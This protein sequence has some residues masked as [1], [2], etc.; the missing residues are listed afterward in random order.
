MVDAASDEP[1][2]FG[3]VKTDPARIAA[4]AQG[5]RRDVTVNLETTRRNLDSLRAYLAG[6]SKDDWRRVGSPL[7]ARRRWTW[8][9]SSR[10]STSATPSSTSTSSTDWPRPRAARRDDRAAP[11]QRPR[12]RLVGAGAGGERLPDPEPPLR[13]LPAERAPRPGGTRRCGHRRARARPRRPR[14]RRPAAV[15]RPRGDVRGVVVEP[16]LRPRPAGLVGDAQRRQPGAAPGQLAGGLVDPGPPPPGRGGAAAAVRRWPTTSTSTPR[17]TTPRTWGACSAPT[18]NRCCPTGSTC[19]SATTAGPARWW[20]AAPTCRDRAGSGWSRARR[21][22]GPSL[23]LDIELEV[24]TVVGTGTADGSAI[25]PDAAAEHVFGFVLLNDW[26]ARD[27]QAFEYQPLGPF[28]GKSFATTISPWVVTL[29][30]LEPYLVEPPVQDPP[31][32]AHLRG[33][34]TVGPRPPPRGRPVRDDGEPHVV[35]RH[36]LD[37]RPAAGPRHVERRLGEAG[38]PAG[39]WHGERTR[40][41]DR[42]QP[43]RAHLARD[44][45]DHAGRRLEPGLPGRRRHGHAPRVVRGRRAR[46]A[47]HRVRRVHGHHRAGALETQES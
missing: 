45:A 26:S 9:A 25:E 10:S 17:S 43:D 33:D 19:P 46:P 15:L 14:A 11:L 29:D 1:V 22:Y 16:A 5:R 41:R 31:P 38:R 42:G 36:V 13:R 39:Q 37:L 44:P 12:P 30:A 34:P 2:P 4:I 24:G 47:P 21:S 35:R 20:S 23:Q 6:L 3:R 18:P 27:I 7:D 8:P 32:A 40:R 28:L